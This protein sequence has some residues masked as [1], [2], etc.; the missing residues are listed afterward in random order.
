[1]LQNTRSVYANF[2]ASISF[3][4]TTSTTQV[5]IHGLDNIEVQDFKIRVRS[6]SDLC[7]IPTL[8]PALLLEFR[9]SISRKSLDNS[10]DILRRVETETGLSPRWWST[11]REERL[12]QK[13]NRRSL[14]EMDFERITRY[15]TSAS[16][17]MAHVEYRCKSHL[18]VLDLLDQ[19]GKNSLQYTQPYQRKV[20]EKDE[21]RVQSLIDR[22]RVSAECTLSRTK[23]LSTRADIQRQT[24]SERVS[25][26]RKSNSL[27]HSVQ[28]YSLIAQKEN[29]LN[30]KIAESSLRVAEATQKENSEMKLISEEMKTLAISALRENSS[31]R[32]LQVITMLFLPATF[33]AVS[34]SAFR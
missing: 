19:I 18:P 28:V 6:V 1:V 16:T 12:V 2:C 3:N 13:M 33:V 7:S 20:H 17:S 27:T 23:Y 5:F 15:I 30:K 24:V 34:H 32:F 9:E 14:D 11:S 8:I 4:P 31:M 22:L 10:E 29:A 21:L 25:L 26:P